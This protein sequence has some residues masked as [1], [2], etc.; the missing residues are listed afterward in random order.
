MT[1]DP[2]IPAFVPDEALPSPALDTALTPG[3]ARPKHLPFAYAKRHGV[4][5]DAI[6]ADH[7]KLLFRKGVPMHTFAEVRRFFGLPL[8]MQMI[9]LDR[10]DSLLQKAYEGGTGAALD[11][12]G[13]M[14]E[15]ANL[16]EIAQEL[17]EPEDLLERDRKS[18]V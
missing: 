16:A 10:F 4:L 5:V 14:D 11:M 1:Q 8:R 18:V 17:N 3:A 9:E 12:M 2:N 15:E 7:V 13:D 6:H